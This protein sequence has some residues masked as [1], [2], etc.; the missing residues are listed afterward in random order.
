MWHDVHGT[1]AWDDA[2]QVRSAG[3][4]ALQDEQ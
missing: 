2:A 3:R 4:L 1:S